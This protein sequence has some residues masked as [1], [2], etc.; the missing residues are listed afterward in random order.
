MKI[1]KDH[2]YRLAKSTLKELDLLFSLRIDGYPDG[3]ARV[4]LPR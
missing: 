4:S 3:R 2:R 1:P